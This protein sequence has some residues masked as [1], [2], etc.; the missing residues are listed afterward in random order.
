MGRASGLIC[1]LLLI[2]PTLVALMAGAPPGDATPEEKGK[3]IYTSGTGSSAKPIVAV[4]SGAEVPASVLPCK[5]CHGADGRG[6]PEG[7]IRPANITADALGAEYHDESSSSGRKRPAYDER[8]LKRAISMG[9][10]AGGNELHSAMP[11]YRM[12]AEDMANLVAYLKALGREHE[13]GLTDSTIDVG[14]PAGAH[15][16]AGD[17]ALAAVRAYFDQVNSDGGIYNRALSLSTDGGAFA[18]LNCGAADDPVSGDPAIP[19]IG[20]TSGAAAEPA[21]GGSTFYLMPGLARQAWALVSYARENFTGR[22]AIVHPSGE[23]WSRL[24]AALID[25]ARPRGGADIV[26]G[27]YDADSTRLAGMLEREHPSAIIIIDPAL[28]ERGSL[29]VIA[30]GAHSPAVLM[31]A[32]FAESDRFD[33]PGALEGRIYLSSPAWL[34]SVSRGGLEGYAR[35]RERYR[36]PADHLG[37]QLV[38]LAGASI[39]VEG[40]KRSG[41]DLNREALVAQLQQLYEFGTGFI[42]PVTYGPNRRVGSDSIYIISIDPSRKGSRVVGSYRSPATMGTEQP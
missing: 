6:R 15:G 12:S 24:A 27:V 42:P 32:S 33:P 17:A 30:R 36:L 38:A 21:R 28:A 35:L 7:G 26:A 25:D 1:A 34:S 23:R 4:L 3:R 9:L 5:S 19:I 39:L 13:T 20:G 16:A 29:A 40:L 37:S 31:P 41:R 14:A 18:M 10:D 2:P 11:R 8:K 22:L